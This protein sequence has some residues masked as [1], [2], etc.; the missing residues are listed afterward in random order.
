[1]TVRS[2]KLILDPEEVASADRAQ[3]DL[4]S[5]SIRVAEGG[6]DWGQAEVDTF[7]AK[8][9]MGSLPIDTEW[10][11]RTITIPLLVGASGDFDAARI[12]LQEKVGRINEEG[13]WLKR[14]IIGGSYGEAGAYLFADIVKATLKL[15]GDSTQ[16]REG[17]D[18]NAQLTL[19]AL[20]DFYGDPI[21]LTAFEGTG[22]AA[23]TFQIKGNMPGRLDM[24]VADLSG[25]DQLGLGWFA[26]CRNYSSAST[27]A[28]AIEAE[29]MTRKTGAEEVAL[30]G[31]SNGKAVLL[32]N[33][34]S[35]WTP[36]LGTNLGGSYLT[37]AGLYDVWARVYTKAVT[38]LP[39]L[40]LVY[41]VGDLI[42]PTTL[43][44][45]QLPGPENFYLVPLGQINL[46]RLPYG[47]HR[48]E[49]I[50]QGYSTAENQGVYIDQLRFFCADESSGILSGTER[51]VA[52][53]TITARDYFL[54]TSGALTGKKADT[55]QT[56]SGEGDADDF[57]VVE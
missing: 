33:L 11:N 46:S 13:G 28:W 25:N 5:G 14:Q 17:V 21:S 55:G 36:I 22:G 3:L 56:W 16:A 4:H 31:A 34:G 40:R 19:E 1:M 20:P 54:Q 42:N 2:E 52:G 45:I 7:M 51:L 26:R 9:R 12:L 6:P 48:W 50:L 39:W 37:H 44:P 8:L 57:S 32:P 47:T 24:T 15:G 35:I 23:S 27:A 18:A 43:A 53:T 38:G 49:G 30:T 41:D 29:S 10:P